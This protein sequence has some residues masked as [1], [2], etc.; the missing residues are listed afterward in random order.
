MSKFDKNT[1][2]KQKLFEI[3]SGPSEEGENMLDFQIVP[4][5]SLEANM[6][7]DWIDKLGGEIA[8]LFIE[9]ANRA[10]EGE[11]A[12]A[13]DPG[14]IKMI[15]RVN[16]EGY[17]YIEN[18]AMDVLQNMLDEMDESKAEAFRH[19]SMVFSNKIIDLLHDHLDTIQSLIALPEGKGYKA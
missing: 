4:S 3:Y 6:D 17:M 13:E 1:E 12:Q 7:S 9:Y 8:D 10:A 15:A 2:G 14:I 18:T 11:D 5:E 19:L 16:K